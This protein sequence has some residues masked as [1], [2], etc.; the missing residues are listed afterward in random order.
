LSSIIP[1]DR[2]EAN[3]DVRIPG[4]IIQETFD[5]ANTNGDNAD[6]NVLVSILQDN[7][8]VRMFGKV[9][10]TK[11]KVS[12]NDPDIKLVQYFYVIVNS[13][14]VSTTVLTGGTTPD[15]TSSNIGELIAVENGEI[16]P[17]YDVIVDV[18]SYG[19]PYITNLTV[20]LSPNIDYVINLDKSINI[21]SMKV[22]LIYFDNRIG[23][24]KLPVEVFAPE[25]Y[26]EWQDTSLKTLFSFDGRQTWK[27]YD[28]NSDFWIASD[29]QNIIEEG[30]TLEELN[31]IISFNYSGWNNSFR[32]SE[33]NIPPIYQGFIE[34]STEKVILLAGFETL[35]PAHTPVFDGI[36][37]NFFSG[38]FWTPKN[39]YSAG[40]FFS[41]LF[42]LV[43]VQM[44]SPTVTRV[45][46]KDSLNSG[47]KTFK[48]TVNL[49][50]NS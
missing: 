3:I 45:I 35:E 11:F 48:A 16:D 23:R 5:L 7:P 20:L 42:S 44:L 27:R 21:N 2:L 22:D 18:N 29:P 15:F 43:E 19:L 6:T 34:G 9:T 25:T 37:M 14:G 10:F 32:A 8:F 47:I 4:W 41:G 36:T 28:P 17:N 33:R 50:R 31:E 13:F 1:N 38:S 39:F 24:M 30:M 40:T 26:V 46:N 49:K 12:T